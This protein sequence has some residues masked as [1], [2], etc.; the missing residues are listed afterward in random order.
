MTA[1]DAESVLKLRDAQH[2]DAVAAPLSAKEEERSWNSN[3][4]SFVPLASAMFR[5]RRGSCR[6]ERITL[7]YFL[8]KI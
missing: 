2:P 8:V 3:C 7:S 1:P 6:S 4:M 5:S